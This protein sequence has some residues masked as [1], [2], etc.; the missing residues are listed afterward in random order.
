MMKV[1]SKSKYLYYNKL[2]IIL[3]ITV[4]DLYWYDCRVQMLDSSF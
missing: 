2:R 4:A 3:F 1:I